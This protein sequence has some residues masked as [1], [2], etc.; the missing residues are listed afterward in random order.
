MFR[1]GLE[2]N[3]MLSL[4]AIMINLEII[5]QKNLVMSLISKIKCFQFICLLVVWYDILLKI[6]MATK[7]M[8]MT[9]LQKYG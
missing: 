4:P 1:L 3:M 8:Q 5:T 7:I 6:N 9:W 2:K